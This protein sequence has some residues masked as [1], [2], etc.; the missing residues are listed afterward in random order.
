VGLVI[1]TPPA[2]EPVSLAEI[3]L[4]LRI[5]PDVSAEDDLLNSLIKAARLHAERVTGRALVT[6]TQKLTLDYFPEWGIELPN[7]PLQSVTSVVYWDLN[8]TQQT[9]AAANY[10]VVTATTPGFV[11]PAYGEV[12]PSTLEIS[13]AVEITFVA[14][15]GAAAAVP[16]DLKAA[17]KLLVGHWYR[18]RESVSATGG[19]ELPQA[20][21][22]LLLGNWTGS[23]M[24]AN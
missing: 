19:I 4:H 6:Q 15:Y 5:E 22:M 23:Y 21:D 17:I 20:V 12:W 14:G 7:P 24:G 11:E 1:V 18:N 9:L 2:A 16:D 13:G 3:K 10:K 8:E